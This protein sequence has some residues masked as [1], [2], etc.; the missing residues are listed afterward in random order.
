MLSLCKDDLI[1]V[2]SDELWM[3]SCQTRLTDARYPAI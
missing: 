3:E 1:F 2:S